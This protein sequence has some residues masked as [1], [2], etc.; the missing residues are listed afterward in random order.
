MRIGYLVPQFPAQTHIF[1][2]R[3]LQALK[4]MGVDPVLLSTPTA[5]TGA[6][7]AR[8]VAGS[9][10]GHQLF[11]KAGPAGG[12]RCRRCFGGVRIAGRRQCR[13]A[14]LYERYCP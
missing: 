14:R 6:G 5:A 11:G 8:L 7:R 13:A 2:W 4:S 10:A 3:E 1:Y 12:N 9:R